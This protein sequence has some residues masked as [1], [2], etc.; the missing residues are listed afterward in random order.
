MLLVWLDIWAEVFEWLDRSGLVVVIV[1]GE[2]GC[3]D[4]EVTLDIKQMRTGNRSPSPMQTV[5]A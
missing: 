1:V 3:C 4:Q 5:L 2:G